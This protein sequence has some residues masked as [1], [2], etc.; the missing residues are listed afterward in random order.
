M[1]CSKEQCCRDATHVAAGFY[2]GK[3]IFP[4]TTQFAML[5]CD[6]HYEQEKASPDVYNYTRSGTNYKGRLIPVQE[7]EVLRVKAKL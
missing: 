2:C 1:K 5:Y 3:F 4:K 7:W 6:R